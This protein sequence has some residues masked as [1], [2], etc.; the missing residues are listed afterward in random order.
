MMDYK[1]G[2]LV[3]Y[4]KEF[5]VFFRYVKPDKVDCEIFRDPKMVTVNVKQITPV[6]DDS[7][8][9]QGYM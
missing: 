6:K 3:Y 5:Y 1:K 8:I 2:D 7:K 9:K 4:K